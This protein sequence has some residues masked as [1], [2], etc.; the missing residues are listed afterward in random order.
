[1]AFA[2]GDPPP[3]GAR[4]PLRRGVVHARVDA[5]GL[6]AVDVLVAHFKSN[7]PV[8]L[9]DARGELVPPATERAFAEGHLRS[10]VWRAAEA[11]FVRGLV[12]ELLAADP[13]GHVAVA[14]DLNDRPGSHVVRIVCGGGDRA[15][16]PC[17]DAVPE[18]ARF[19]ILRRGAREQID[20]AL[21]TAG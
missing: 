17:A 10:L 5:P 19:S 13:A 14:G 21:V 3:F 20:H 11:L 8:P 9:R 12:D 6:G 1:P 15:L 18:A 2:E 7:R 16:L 4:I